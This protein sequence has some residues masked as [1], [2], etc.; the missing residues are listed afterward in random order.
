MKASL[1]FS[2]LP[3]AGLLLAPAAAAAGDLPVKNCEIAGC[4]GN[5]PIVYASPIEGIAPGE[6]NYRGIYLEPTVARVAPPPATVLP[7]QACPD[8]AT[9]DVHLGRLVCRQGHL[10]FSGR[11]LIGIA[12]TL[13]IPAEPCDNL[14]HTGTLPDCAPIPRLRVRVRLD[15]LGAIDTWEV[16]EPT[17]VGTYRMVWHELTDAEELEE[18]LVLGESICP[19]QRGW[20]DPW[21]DPRSAGPQW[22][23]RPDD[24]RWPI[25]T[26]HLL[27]VH[28]ETY[29]SDGSIERRGASA[30][31]WFNLACVGSALAKMRLL[32][33][34]PILQQSASDELYRAATLKML[35]G[36][37]RGGRSYTSPG[38]ALHYQAKSGKQFYGYPKGPISNHLESYW[39]AYGATCVSHRRTWQH[40]TLE[41][42]PSPLA[43]LSSWLTA[44]RPEGDLDGV[45]PIIPNP[46]NVSALYLSAEE[47][48]LNEEV[49]SNFLIPTCSPNVW[50]GDSY[51]R[52]YPISH[53]H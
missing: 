52:T 30:T 42:S 4:G 9:L 11:A 45:F 49:R 26:D 1:I 24:N 32:G 33:V 38:M 22:S 21:Q 48:S 3:L 53:A 14:T 19:Q 31:E 17:T 46:P 23:L 5:T 12:L 20:M 15:E 8:G 36:R 39:A 25:E 27:I 2:L 34:N 16:V 28:G 41:P 7:G 40:R 10:T 37:Y 35:T 43:Q 29:Y 18:E 47:A 6:T 50:P 44:A 13:W 51:W